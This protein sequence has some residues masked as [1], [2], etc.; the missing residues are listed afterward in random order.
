L[1]RLVELSRGVL[2]LWA[3]VSPLL[4]C[5]RREA[6]RVEQRRGLFMPHRAPLVNRGGA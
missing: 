1:L 5:E 2:A 4:P 3:S 6:H